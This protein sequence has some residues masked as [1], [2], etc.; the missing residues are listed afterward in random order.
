M[1]DKSISRMT[2]NSLKEVLDKTVQKGENKIEILIGT[3]HMFFHDAKYSNFM[4]W[5]DIKLTQPPRSK[6]LAAPLSAAN[7]LQQ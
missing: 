3:S 7:I 4:N 6:A 5:D 2:R 1:V